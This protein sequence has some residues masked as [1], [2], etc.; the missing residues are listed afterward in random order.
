M[1]KAYEM[2]QT[3]WS[4]PEKLLEAL[5]EKGRKLGLK[6]SDYVKYVL[7]KDVAEEFEDEYELSEEDVASI[8]KSRE[9]AKSGIGT[10]IK[11]DADLKAY[12]I[13]LKR[14]SK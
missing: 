6:L 8:Q 10:E 13:K 4:Y 11:N 5:E 7:T 3:H 1:A 2:K 14:K 9:Q 12:V